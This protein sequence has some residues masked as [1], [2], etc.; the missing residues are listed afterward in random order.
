MENSAG[1]STWA[2]D[3]NL[4]QQAKSITQRLD[5]A[6]NKTHRSAAR[7]TLQMRP[8]VSRSK[9]L[10]LLSEEFHFQCSLMQKT[11]SARSITGT[12]SMSPHIDVS[13]W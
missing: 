10:Q 5:F 3:R 7:A 9:F 2:R 11:D 4:Q 12:P 1:E 13:M 8:K 6:I